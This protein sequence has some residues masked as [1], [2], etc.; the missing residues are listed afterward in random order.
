MGGKR[1]F[2]RRESCKITKV[3]Y[4][5]FFSHLP[6]IAHLEAKLCENMCEQDVQISTFLN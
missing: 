2:W 6:F 4:Q 1:E 5:Q 3:M